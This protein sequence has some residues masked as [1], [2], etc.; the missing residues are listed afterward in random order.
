[1]LTVD[2]T[3]GSRVGHHMAIAAENT[4]D[5][6]TDPG[7]LR[8]YAQLIDETKALFGSEHY[9]N[10]QFLVAASD[11]AGRG[12][13]FEHGESSDNGVGSDYFRKMDEVAAIAAN[14]SGRSWR[15]LQDSADA[16][17]LTMA[18]MYGD[19]DYDWRSWVGALDYYEDSALIWLEAGA[20]ISEQ[21]GGRRTLDNFM[22]AFTAAKA[23][24]PKSR[25]IRP[26]MSSPRSTGFFP[27]T[28]AASSSA[29]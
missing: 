23:D 3:P 17:P 13:G 19:G 20:I 28:G 27:T 9:T 11:Y 25:L 6:P 16:V 8:H 1:M 10:Y 2:L 5:L 12:A 18:Q 7:T 21:T 26:G 29:A 24:A 22:A 14:R 4:A 15:P